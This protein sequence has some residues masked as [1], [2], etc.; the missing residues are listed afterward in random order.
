M[1]SF[2]TLNTDFLDPDPAVL[3]D[4]LEERLWN[5]ALELSLLN[6]K[7]RIA[8]D[9]ALQP[10]RTKSIITLLQQCLLLD[11]N[12]SAWEATARADPRSFTF[13]ASIDTDDEYDQY[14]FPPDCI[15]YDFLYCWGFRLLLADVVVQLLEQTSEDLTVEA[16]TRD[17]SDSTTGLTM[18]LTAAS[19]KA[20]F[21]NSRHSHALQIMRGS[22]FA[23]SLTAGHY[24]AYR[25]SFGILS[26]LYAFHKS[27]DA[28]SI[29]AALAAVRLLVEKRG[30]S[31]A[32]LALDKLQPLLNG[33]YIS[34]GWV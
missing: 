24:G 1:S 10:S 29:A 30:L 16:Q 23:L 3:A 34:G 25:V 13:M 17:L 19:L 32:S 9:D 5:L 28:V 22:Q 14:P 15:G 27:D 2:L 7:V 8:L 18:P 11:E 33:G 21:E 6:G 26:A 20:S 12:F 31:F 4:D